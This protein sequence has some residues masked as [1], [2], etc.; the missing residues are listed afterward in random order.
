MIRTV[1]FLGSEGSLW[2]PR[3]ERTPWHWPCMHQRL[4]F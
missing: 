4:R 1:N 3:A 2:I